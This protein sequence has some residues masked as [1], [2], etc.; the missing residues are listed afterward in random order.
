MDTS[1]KPAIS[2]EID[3]IVE[4]VTGMFPRLHVLVV[5]P[6]LSRDEIMLETTKR[7]LVKA[8]ERDMPVVIDADGLFLVQ[9]DPSIVKGFH[10][11]VLTPNANEFKRLCEVMKVD[12]DPDHK[13]KAAQSL[14]DAFGNVT[15]VQKGSVDV[16]S[17]GKQVITCD[18]PGSPRRC[19][20]QG[21][22]L[23]GSLA[24]FL[25]WGL[26]YKN[27]TW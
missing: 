10:S 7:I 15:I 12:P 20:G 1:D 24:T 21:D 27:E 5:G 16:I 17:N 9:N 11:A 8:R 3:R 26:G 22:L 18:A 13:D 23:S 14:S 6:G 4:R 2:K 19:G 25:A